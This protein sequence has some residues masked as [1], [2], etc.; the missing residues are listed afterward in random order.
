MRQ[1]IIISL[2]SILVSCANSQNKRTTDYKNIL[3]NVLKIE[4]F[5]PNY[6]VVNVI[7]HNTLNKREICC[8]STDLVYALH[9]DSVEINIDSVD[10]D[11]NGIPI[12]KIKSKRALEQLRFFQYNIVTVDSLTKY[13]PHDLIEKI[14]IENRKNS[15]SK[16]L[17]LNSTKFPENYFEHFLLR[18]GILTYRDCESGF[19]VI[20]NNE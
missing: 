11:E 20:L 1:F 8:E 6:I 15:Y 14:I 17:E 13:T 12:F 10:Y 18:N 3:E 5:S 9:L 16:L 19:T 4:F 7:D 2:S